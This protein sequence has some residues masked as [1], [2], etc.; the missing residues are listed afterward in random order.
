MFPIKKDGV[1]LKGN[2]LSFSLESENDWFGIAN[3][4]KS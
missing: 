3:S 2:A 4:N 1:S